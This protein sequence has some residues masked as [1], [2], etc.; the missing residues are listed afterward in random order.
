MNGLKSNVGGQNSRHSLQGTGSIPTLRIQADTP[1]PRSNGNTPVPS[2][3]DKV[4]LPALSVTP[5]IVQQGKPCPQTAT[6]RIPHPNQINNYYRYG[7]K[8]GKSLSLIDQS[9]LTRVFVTWEYKRI[10]ASPA[11]R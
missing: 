9:K 2:N 10:N 3:P 1:V 8:S 6:P 4:Q 11:L 5:R 7:N